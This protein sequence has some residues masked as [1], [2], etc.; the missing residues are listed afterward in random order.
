MFGQDSS[1]HLSFRVDRFPGERLCHVVRPRRRRRNLIPIH[2]QGAVIRLRSAWAT[3]GVPTER[4]VAHAAAE[5]RD[6]HHVSQSES[7]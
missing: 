4:L 5:I 3:I 2:V 7:R 1:P 6:Q